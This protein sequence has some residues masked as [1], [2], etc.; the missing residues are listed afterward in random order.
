MIG[1]PRKPA[2]KIPITVGWW[3]ELAVICHYRFFWLE[4]VVMLWY[5]CRFFAW[6]SSDSCTVQKL[7]FSFHSEHTHP[8]RHLSPPVSP[9]L[10]PLFTKMLVKGLGFWSIAWARAFALRLVPTIHSFE[11]VGFQ[12]F[13][14]LDFKVCN[15]NPFKFDFSYEINLLLDVALKDLRIYFIWLKYGWLNPIPLNKD[16]KL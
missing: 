11:F 1:G 9:L 13:W 8:R 3:L 6:A 10:R 2:A 15:R 4:P 16:I 14:W 7:T 12:L 5:H